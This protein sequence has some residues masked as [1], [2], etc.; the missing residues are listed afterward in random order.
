MILKRKN[1]YETQLK[2]HVKTTAQKLRFKF[3]FL[4][5]PII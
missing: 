1:N 2:K 3:N 5:S 4:M